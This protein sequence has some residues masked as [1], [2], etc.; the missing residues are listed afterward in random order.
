MSIIIAILIGAFALRII[1]F[2]CM[3]TMSKLLSE[4]TKT[5]LALGM[6]SDTL[7]QWVEEKHKQELHRLEEEAKRAEETAKRAEETEKREFEFKKMQEERESLN[8]RN[9]RKNLHLLNIG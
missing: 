8:S 1:A 7:I 2:H 5:G 9:Y 6:T 4:L 3:S